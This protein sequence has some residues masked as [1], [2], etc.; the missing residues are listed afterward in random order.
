MAYSPAS[1]PSTNATSPS[2]EDSS[3]DGDYISEDGFTETYGIETLFSSICITSSGEH[4]GEGS[5]HNENHLAG[6]DSTRNNDVEILVPTICITSPFG[7]DCVYDT[8]SKDD[9]SEFD[10]DSTEFDSDSDFDFEQDDSE[11]E[12]DYD[13][14]NGTRIYPRKEFHSEDYA[15]LPSWI[16]GIDSEKME[17]DFL[18]E[19]SL[20]ESVNARRKQKANEVPLWEF[21]HCACYISCGSLDESLTRLADL[22]KTWESRSKAEK[23]HLRLSRKSDLLPCDEWI[24]NEMECDDL[25]GRKIRYTGAWSHRNSRKPP[26]PS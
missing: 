23:Q 14:E 12:Q 1:I 24:K 19:G 5:G 15:G 8:D 4:C 6:S 17:R 11:S 25:K 13:Q 20:N 7:E 10:S 16:I 21:P 3:H 18:F 9:S 22:R 26:Y 2:R